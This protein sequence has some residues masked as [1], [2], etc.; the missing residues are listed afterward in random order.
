MNTPGSI[1]EPIAITQAEQSWIKFYA[2]QVAGVKN[3]PIPK[4]GTHEEVLGIA[5]RM[6]PGI[7]NRDGAIHLIK[8][9][10][11][12]E[13]GNQ[14]VLHLSDTIIEEIRSF[15][16]RIEVALNID[17]TDKAYIEQPE[18]QE[19]RANAWL[20]HILSEH[21]EDLRPGEME[22]LSEEEKQ[23]RM[24]IAMTGLQYS[25]FELLLHSYLEKGRHQLNTIRQST[26]KEALEHNE[27]GSENEEAQR[28]GYPLPTEEILQKDFLQMD[29]RKTKMKELRMA[30]N[31]DE[32]AAYEADCCN[33]IY[34]AFMG[35]QPTDTARRKWKANTGIQD[36]AKTKIRDCLGAAIQSMHWMKELD[37]NVLMLRTLESPILDEGHMSMIVIDAKG[38]RYFFDPALRKPYTHMPNDYYANA[39][40]DRLFEEVQ[41]GKRKQFRVDAVDVMKA[42]VEINAPHGVVM[43][44]EDGMLQALQYVTHYAKRTDRV[45]YR[46]MV[47]TYEKIAGNQKA[48]DRMPMNF[49]E[50]KLIT[51]HYYDGDEGV[52]VRGNTLIERYPDS[53][54]MLNQVGL[55]LDGI[56]DLQGNFNILA[57]LMQKTFDAQLCLN[58]ATSELEKG[59]CMPG[60]NITRAMLRHLHIIESIERVFDHLTMFI[61]H[62]KYSP[63]LQKFYNMFMDQ[64]MNQ[65]IEINKF[66]RKRGLISETAAIE[67]VIA[68]GVTA[69][70]RTLEMLRRAEKIKEEHASTSDEHHPRGSG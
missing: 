53:V 5:T 2:R 56:G 47:T 32:I 11:S 42:Y 29:I 17:A 23:A 33:A 43:S 48:S 59:V 44:C 39:N 3:A 65:I 60:K 45:A 20:S 7:A 66:A 49:L 13:S 15:R 69:G 58:A 19:R 25:P 14:R 30:G 36:I 61:S 67:K 50:G 21:Y 22:K 24:Y 28:M 1:H 4:K 51:D 54:H 40:I 6:D 63:G 18:E 31:I 62:T 8:N 64:M 41:S 70:A 37:I 26:Q 10:R 12:I 38:G 52:Q 57:I 9:L 35:Y 16:Q 27:S 55:V 68:R 34:A 46:N